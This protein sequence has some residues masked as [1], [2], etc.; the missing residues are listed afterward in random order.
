MVIRLISWKNV[1]ASTMIA[2][3]FLLLVGLVSI[4]GVNVQ[5]ADHWE[6]I[7]IV[8]AYHEGTLGFDDFFAQHN[9]H[10]IPLPKMV[11]FGLAWL[12][13]WN[14]AYEMAFGIVVAAIGFLFL[15]SMLRRTFHTG[16]GFVAAATLTGLV[17]FSPLQSE[18]WLWGW[19]IDWFMVC[20]SLV[21]AVWALT[22]W[23]VQSNLARTAVATL[24][25]VA[26]SFSLGAGLLVWFVGLPLFLVSKP[27][28]VWA[29]PWAA[30]ATATIAVYYTDYQ[31][32][33][34]DGGIALLLDKPVDMT[35]YVMV[36]LARP[37]LAAETGTGVSIAA[38]SL[39]TAGLLTALGLAVFALWRRGEDRARLTGWVSLAVFAMV[40]AAIT[41]SS[42]LS[43]G[44]EQAST[45][46]YTTIAQFLVI[47]VAVT[48]LRLL[49]ARWREPAES[50]RVKG[51]PAAAVALVAA[52]VLAGY[53][54]GILDMRTNH[55][56]FLASQACE[57]KVTSPDDPCL[58]R[59]YYDKKV[60]WERLQY[61]RGVGWGDVG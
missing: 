58:G 40:A 45:S 25:A 57:R 61:L 31:P 53:P 59:L 17:W 15:L 46:R 11:L 7:G 8:R 30:A 49:E 28:R 37:L 6:F 14:T 41:A 9:E 4:F 43:L 44:I 23:R 19:Q 42:R 38:A 20:T 1:S 60:V 51:V 18:N 24:A 48:M 21:I 35:R 22:A 5:W 3:P 33:P 52:L 16:K 56:N 26:A 55:E 34:D 29:L 27:M 13:G 10:R 50:W 2:A 54:R 47:A 32:G 39:V 12:S 36:Y